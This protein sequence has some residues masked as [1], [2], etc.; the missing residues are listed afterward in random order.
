WEER[1]PEVEGHL[2][3]AMEALLQNA[4][5]AAV[6]VAANLSDPAVDAGAE[7][8]RVRGVT[9]VSALAV[10]DAD[11]ALV[12]WEGTHQGQ[13]PDDARNGTFPFL[14][15]DGPLFGYMYSTAPIPETGG[16]VVAAILMRADLPFSA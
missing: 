1:R 8:R 3:G 10:Y 12:A 14:Y 16:V 5:R 11:G 15:G 7:L 6:E 4:D 2:E 13:V 9:G